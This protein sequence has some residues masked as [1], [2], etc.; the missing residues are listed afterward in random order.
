MKKAL[1]KALLALMLGV[2]IM[3]AMSVQAQEKTYPYIIEG[4]TWNQ[5]YGKYFY[6]S[7]TPDEV[8]AAAVQSWSKTTHVTPAKPQYDPSYDIITEG[9]YHG[10][11]KIRLSP[12]Y[13]RSYLIC[14]ASLKT[15]Y[16]YPTKPE[17]NRVIMINDFDEA[18]EIKKFEEFPPN[19]SICA[20][21]AIVNDLAFL[22]C[23]NSSNYTFCF[24][25]ATIGIVSNDSEARQYIYQC[26]IEHEDSHKTDIGSICM[27]TGRHGITDT[28][29]TQLNYHTGE[30]NGYR[31]EE[32]CLNSKIKSC[33]SSQCVSD[34]SKRIEYTR[35]KIKDH[36]PKTK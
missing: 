30:R 28:V 26:T 19:P 1:K 32:A 22:G 29:L 31:A 11:Y 12:P 2:G 35:T 34:I 10:S 33:T 6:F 24:N 25:E 9:I 21:K 16:I 27:T 23:A 20:G 36:T 18:V 14:D 7:G 15:S 8:C 17:L 4:R 5:F 3:G 13:V